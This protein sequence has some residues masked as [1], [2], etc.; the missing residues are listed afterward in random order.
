MPLES[1]VSPRGGVSVKDFTR[2]MA[3]TAQFESAPQLLVA[4]SG[5][6]DSMVL[7]YLAGI[8]ARQNNATVLAVT[9]DHTVRPESRGEAESVGQWAA[10]M[11]IAHQIKTLDSNLVRSQTIDQAWLRRLRYRA[12]AEVAREQGIVHILTAHHLNDQAETLLLRLGRGSGL[13]GLS[14]MQPRVFTAE[15][16][17][18]RPLLTLTKSQIANTC[19]AAGLPWV[20][21]PSNDNPH[22]DRVKVRIYADDL[23]KVGLTA[24]RL[25]ETAARLGTDRAMQLRLRD[26]FLAQQGYFHPAGFV[27]LSGRPWADCDRAIVRLAL[28][29]L[30]VVVGKGEFA[31]RAESIERLMES[32][33]VHEQINC[34]LGGCRLV[35]R[36]DE[37]LVF[38]ETSAMAPP[39]SLSNPMALADWDHRF[40]VIWQGDIGGGWTFGAMAEHE[41][42]D[43]RKPLLSVGIPRRIMVTLPVI[44]RDGVVIHLPHLPETMKDSPFFVEAI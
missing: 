23:A 3:A 6:S 39:V 21:D 41:L 33:A 29:R 44:R 10:E 32:L 16:Q 43:W 24:E 22:Y 20:R 37:L 1:G 11:G 36:E 13:M 14:A 28:M 8:W 42:K 2:L 27:R 40:R 5:G 25:A 7:L 17:L 12:L 4:V 19:L 15:F 35:A 31:P 38:R 34:C 18:L 26:Q 30:L 9:V